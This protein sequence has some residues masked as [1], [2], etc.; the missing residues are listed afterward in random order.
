[1]SDEIF[2]KKV[3]F[4]YQTFD[5]VVPHISAPASG[6][7]FDQQKTIY[8][9]YKNRLFNPLHWNSKIECVVLFHD[10]A[11]VDSYLTVFR[12]IEDDIGYPCTVTVEDFTDSLDSFKDDL[13]DP[14]YFNEIFWVNNNVVS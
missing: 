11:E 8:P 5:A 7:W 14:D 1:M 3:T 13:Q 12:Q 6:E 9:S 4:D 2:T 10:Q